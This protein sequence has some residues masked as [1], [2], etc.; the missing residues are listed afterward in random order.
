[1]ASTAVSG[2]EAEAESDL[3]AG[4]PVGTKV[5][6]DTNVLLFN[7]AEESPW[8]EVARARINQIQAAG[9]EFWISRQVIRELLVAATRPGNLREPNPPSR[10]I[11]IARELQSVMRVASD[12]KQVTGFLLDLLETPG[13]LGKQVHDANI[14]ATMRAN[15]IT[16][17]L[18]HNTADFARYANLITALP[19]V[20]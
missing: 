8:H 2:Q 11:S 7:F 16:H 17:L 13:A 4:L 18:T 15:K 20:P 19:L 5:F 3:P 9:A 14:V 10:W 12:D 6:I 1:M